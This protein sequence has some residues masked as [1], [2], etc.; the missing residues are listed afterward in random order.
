MPFIVQFDIPSKVYEAAID[1]VVWEQVKALPHKTLL[2]YLHK[3]LESKGWSL[4]FRDCK[5]DLG[6]NFH[7]DH[8]IH[9]S[10]TKLSF[11]ELTAVIIHECYHSIFAQLDEPNVLELEKKVMRKLTVTQANKI[12]QK[13]FTSGKWKFAGPLIKNVGADSEK[14]K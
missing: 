2:D 14:K 9:I 6:A 12:L 11:S 5:E 1:S 3:F 4:T 13:V 7:P 8:D 10:S